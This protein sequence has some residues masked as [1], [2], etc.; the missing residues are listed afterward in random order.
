MKGTLLLFFLIFFLTPT[1]TAVE[2]GTVYDLLSSEGAGYSETA[3]G[4]AV[5]DAMVSLSGADLAILPAGALRG[6]LRGGQVSWDEICRAVDDELSLAV[7]QVTS[8]Q[9]YSLLEFGL[10]QLTIDE[11]EQLDREASAS[12]W[13]PQ[14]AGFDLWIDVSAPIG[15]RVYELQVDKR[16]VT[17]RDEAVFTLCTSL[18]LLQ[19]FGISGEDINTSPA[20]MLRTYILSG[21]LE[22][23]VEEGRIRMLGTLDDNFMSNFSPFALLIIVIVMVS[24]AV[25]YV[26]YN[27]RSYHK[28]YGTR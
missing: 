25:L 11:T 13:F 22:E 19:Q 24:F 27:G 26:R 4:N 14:I 20:S 2:T 5:T 12:Q 18:A 8:A 23:P 10:E 7:A 15:E 6:N 28:R 3:L 16:A 21:Q 1:A 9:L 17:R